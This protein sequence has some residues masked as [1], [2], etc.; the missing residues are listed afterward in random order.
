MTYDD[1]LKVIKDS[2]YYKVLEPLKPKKGQNV[3]LT[4][5]E[6][7]LYNHLYEIVFDVI[8]KYVKGKAR[9]ELTDFFKLYIK[10]SAGF[11]YIPAVYG[12]NKLLILYITNYYLSKEFTKILIPGPIVVVI[13]IFL[14]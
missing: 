11:I 13:A 9:Q 2:H 3:D 1:F 5:M 6:T 12:T 4:L 10:S 14:T 8:N 7:A